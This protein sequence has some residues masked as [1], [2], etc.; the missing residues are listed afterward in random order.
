MSSITKGNA[1]T[2]ST[3]TQPAASS[4]AESSSVTANKAGAAAENIER[5]RTRGASDV[6]PGKLGT[7]NA[8]RSDR[9]A[10][11]IASV[12]RSMGLSSSGRGVGES[13]SA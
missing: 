12:T 6:A 2:A 13:G 4:R 7:I 5:S 1:N 10:A 11:D 8:A 3:Q 9:E